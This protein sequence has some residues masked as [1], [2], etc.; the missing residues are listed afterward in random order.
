M[1]NGNNRVISAY[2]LAFRYRPQSE[3]SLRSFFSSVSAIH[4]TEPAGQCI[5]SNYPFGCGKFKFTHASEAVS[6]ALFVCMFPGKP[7]TM[8]VSPEP[9]MPPLMRKKREK[10]EDAANFSKGFAGM[11]YEK[12]E[13]ICLTNACAHFML[14]PIKNGASQKRWRLSTVNAAAFSHW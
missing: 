4:M 9:A 11:M 6:F 3:R 12:N 2:V 8:T 14:K 13:K 1:Q 7:G 10:E 5:F